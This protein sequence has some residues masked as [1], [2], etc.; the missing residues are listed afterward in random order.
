[1]SDT[2]RIEIPLW[3]IAPDRWVSPDN[4]KSFRVTDS[5]IS[6]EAGSESLVIEIERTVQGGEA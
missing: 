2:E 3:E 5:E 1:M 4:E 6:G